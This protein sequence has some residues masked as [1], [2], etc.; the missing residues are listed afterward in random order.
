MP[1]TYEDS[2]VKHW[3]T[4]VKND[5]GQKSE[6]VRQ[7]NIKDKATGDHV[8]HN[9]STGVQGVALTDYRPGRK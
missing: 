2:K 7:M 8:F 1:R 4:N 3:N 9:V 6:E 5:A